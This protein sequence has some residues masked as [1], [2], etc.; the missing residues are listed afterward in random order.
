M[1]MTT[2]SKEIVL[3]DEI[4]NDF[5]VIST[6]TKFV[7]LFYMTLIGL[8]ILFVIFRLVQLFMAIGEFNFISAPLII[9]FSLSIGIY[10]FGILIFRYLFVFSKEMKNGMNLNDSGSFSKGIYALKQHAKTMSLMLIMM[11]VLLLGIFL[12]GLIV[13]KF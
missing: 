4:L 6:R 2:K 3:T 9:G 5:K 12:F 10:V 13:S 1:I 11:L 7:S 8:F